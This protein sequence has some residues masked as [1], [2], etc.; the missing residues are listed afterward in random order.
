M[1]FVLGTAVLLRHWDRTGAGRHPVRPCQLVLLAF[2]FLS[3]PST[4]FCSHTHTP[5]CCGPAAACYFLSSPSSARLGT[6]L[7]AHPLRARRT[8]PPLGPFLSLSGSAC[9]RTSHSCLAR[10][11]TGTGGEEGRGGNP[12]NAGK[13]VPR[14]H[15]R[16]AG[17][18]RF[19]YS[20]WLL[21]AI[22]HKTPACAGCP[23]LRSPPDLSPNSPGS[24]VSGFL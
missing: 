4:L 10:A 13:P 20:A 18:S 17:S 3:D 8:P 1:P 16:A 19:H 5:V 7:N 24:S 23:G 9:F 2:G 15:C 12:G 21:A 14:S 6:W 11:W 22:K